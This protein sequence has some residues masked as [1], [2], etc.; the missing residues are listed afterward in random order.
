MKKPLSYGRQWIDEDDVE[1]VV[2]ALRS[3]FLTQGPAIA[4]FENRIQELT[5]ARYCV[6]FSNATSALHVSVAALGL[7]PGDEGITTPNTFVAS[8]NCLAYNQITPCFAD[9]NARTYC[10][11]PQE[12]EKRI[13]PRTKVL[14]PVD[15]A[16][17]PA[18]MRAIRAIAVRNDLFVIEDAAHAIGSAYDDGSPVGSCRFSDLTVF[19]FHPV[20]TITTG[21][22]GAVTTN[23]K[24]LYD[25]IYILRSHGITKSPEALGINPGPWYYEMQDLGF[26]YRMTDIQAALGASQLRK[27]DLFKNR[28]RRIVNVY[29]ERLAGIPFITLPYE[30]P[31]VDSCFH[32]YVIQV[33]FVSLGKTRK[34]VMAELQELGVGTQVHYIPV[35]T[36]PYYRKTYGTKV[37]DCPIAESYYDRALSIPLFPG[38][39]DDDVNLVIE[40]VRKVIR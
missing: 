12:I 24:T 13:T 9:I 30:S 25:R 18:D 23:D 31:K 5:G 1:A 26:N 4:E 34:Q 16:G 27:L 15:F 10:I 7:K 35:H 21:E 29:N 11:D 2:Q 38:M 14:I 32:L 33:D 37:G 20:K 19:S 6:A 3:D 40:S 17:Q 22:G 39:D 36:Q 28:R 8:A